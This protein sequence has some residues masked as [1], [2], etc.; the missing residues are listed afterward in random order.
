[1][2]IGSIPHDTCHTTTHSASM[3]L[4]Y[5]RATRVAQHNHIG[6]HHFAHPA[7]DGRGGTAVSRHPMHCT[8]CTLAVHSS[9]SQHGSLAVNIMPRKG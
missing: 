2:A 5:S 7:A 8:H 3:L 4:H 1:M 6:P 9:Y